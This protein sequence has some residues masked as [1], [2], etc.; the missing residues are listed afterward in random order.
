MRN[1]INKTEAGNKI[2]TTL[3]E[4]ARNGIISGFHGRLGDLGTIPAEYDIAISTACGNLENMIVDNV[5][6]A[7]KCIEHLRQTKAGRANFICLD[8][9]GQQ[10]SGPMES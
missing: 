10:L 4:A 7:E 9:I 6:S 5:A 8:R 3:R 2:K 1:A